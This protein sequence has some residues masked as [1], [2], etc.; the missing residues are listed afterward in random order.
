MT[1]ATHFASNSGA[2]PPGADAYRPGVCN[3]GPAE[4]AR[5]RRTGHVGVIAAAILLVILVALDAPPVT[6]L[7]VAI[8]AMLAASGYLQARFR[9]CA[10]FAARGVFN[11]GA[12]GESQMVT[13][14]ESR[15]RDRAMARRIG[16]ASFGIG[17]LVGG[18]AFLL[19]L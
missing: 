15:A 7:L 17:L 1:Q 13:D 2:L 16:L 6:R 12:V 18:V 19:P 9:F 11:F 5:R 10:G 8:P 3:I 14:A 4:I